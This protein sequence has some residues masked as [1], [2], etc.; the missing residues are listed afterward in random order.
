MQNQN[1]NKKRAQCLSVIEKHCAR[2]NKGLTKNSM[3]NVPLF[4]VAPNDESV[5]LH[6]GLL[7]GFHNISHVFVRHQRPT[8]QTHSYFEEFLAHPVSIGRAILVAGLFVHRFPQRPTLDV[9]PIEPYAQG[10]HVGI[11]LAVGVGIIHKMDDAGRPPPQ[12]FSPWTCRHSP[13][14]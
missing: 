4:S 7:N 5:A 6:D 10:L 11:R 8:G 1:P 12:H 9:G 14:P 2:F 13:A 3:E